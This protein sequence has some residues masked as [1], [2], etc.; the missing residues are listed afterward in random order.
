MLAPARRQHTLTLP[1]ANTSVSMEIFQA[2]DPPVLDTAQ[3]LAK[4]PLIFFKIKKFSLIV[5]FSLKILQIFLFLA[6][7][8]NDKS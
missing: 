5:T 2:D 7:I 1:A 6:K 8:F 4:V 3:L